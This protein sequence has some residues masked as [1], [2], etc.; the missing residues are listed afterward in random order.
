MIT[1]SQIENVVTKILHFA[2]GLGLFVA[3]SIGMNMCAL[4]DPAGICAHIS[5]LASHN[6]TQHPK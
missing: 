1:C 2:P 6:H 4:N 3:T 5:L